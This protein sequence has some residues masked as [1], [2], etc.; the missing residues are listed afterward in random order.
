[1]HLPGPTRPL[2]VAAI[3]TGL[4]SCG[5]LE[6]GGSAHDAVTLEEA[7]SDGGTWAV[8][9]ELLATEIGGATVITLRAPLDEVSCREGG[10]LPTDGLPLG[11]E[12]VFV[13]AGDVTPGAPPLVHA[14]DV[15]VA[16]E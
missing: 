5:I 6:L 10:D 2:L 1:M 3:A 12:L 7:S 16:C 4:V 9:V 15:E 14:V 8:D 13:Q 11:S